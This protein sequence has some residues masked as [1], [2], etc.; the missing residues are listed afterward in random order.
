MMLK[1]LSYNIRKGGGGREM[2]ISAVIRSC[3]P[4]LVILQ[5][6][7]EPA[8][9]ERL[10]AETD[11]T[12]WG[13]RHGYSLGFLSRIEVR[14]HH[15]RNLPE[16]RR[17]LLEVDL[18]E[19][20]I[21]GVHL[22][23]VHSNWTERRRIRELRALLASIETHRD[24]FHVL[25]GDFNTLAPG[26]LLD[27]NRLPLRLR[28]AAW[29]TGGRVRYKTIQMMIDAGYIDGY[30]SLSSDPGFT[31]P[32]WDPHVRLDFLF[33]PGAYRNCVDACEVVFDAPLVHEASDHF[34]LFSKIKIN[35]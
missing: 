5:E 27:L 24:K 21:F 11:M 19:A 13:A 32:T 10:A 22:S 12:S 1:L 15:W 23:A 35:K 16:L 33:L 25:T 29:A 30:R 28:I 7:T 17:P 4:D 8:V 9:V 31:F 34:P 26:E 2:Q 3:E 20:T 18:G 14:E 6:A